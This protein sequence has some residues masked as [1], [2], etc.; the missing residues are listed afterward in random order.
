[1]KTNTKNKSVTLSFPEKLLNAVK[2]E[3]EKK[4]IRVSDYIRLVL[5]EKCSK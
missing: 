4:G 2:K 5:S 3:A 1:M